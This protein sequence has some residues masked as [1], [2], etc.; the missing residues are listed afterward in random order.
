[1]T[2]LLRGFVNPDGI[3]KTTVYVIVLF[4]GISTLSLISEA[5]GP[6]V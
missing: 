5:D 1:M 2:V 3:A 6:G 4:K